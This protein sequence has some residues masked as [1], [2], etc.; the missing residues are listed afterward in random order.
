MISSTL[1][2]IGGCAF[3]C[4]PWLT[5]EKIKHGMV[6][7]NGILV[8]L[9]YRDSDIVIP[10][11][12]ISIAPTAFSSLDITSVTIPDSVKV[13]GYGAFMCCDKLTSITINGNVE[14]IGELAFCNCGNLTNVTIEDGVNAIGD[15][16]FS[17]CYNL[18]SIELPDSL[19][20]IDEGAFFGCENLTSIVIPPNVRII[21][22]NAFNS[23]HA[24]T[25]IEIPEGVKII[26]ERAFSSCHGLVS[27]TVADSVEIIGDCAFMSCPE[28]KSITILN[29]KCDIYDNKYTI[30]NIL[31][32]S[33]KIY[34]GEIRGYSNSTVMNYANNYDYTFVAIDGESD[35]IKG[36]ADDSG[37][38]SVTDVILLQKWL[39]AKKD[40]HL[41][42]WKVVD[43]NNDDKLNIFDLCLMKK[44]LLKISEQ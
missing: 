2:S 11:N 35:F 9:I 10:D 27:V 13:I 41:A 44:E 42:N 23:C 21:G 22:K 25:S 18:T 37:D 15:S 33:K 6:I 32:V 38:F 14:T 40:I 12:V 5:N 17:N 39:L 34:N 29:P 4:T 36:D 26:E 19:T 43:F 31:S 7:I 20:S 8:G 30:S 16:S 1:T 3:E 28:L 24:L